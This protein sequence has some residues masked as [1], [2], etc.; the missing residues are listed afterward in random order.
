[1]APGKQQHTQSGQGELMGSRTLRRVEQ[2]GKCR[3]AP[4]EWQRMA[5]SSQQLCP[6]HSSDVGSQLPSPFKG[7]GCVEIVVFQPREL[8][9][10]MF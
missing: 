2:S 4:G 8:C 6:G 10:S 5:P 9:C 1:M 7:S 3:S